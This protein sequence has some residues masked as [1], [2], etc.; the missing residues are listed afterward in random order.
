MKIDRIKAIPVEIPLST[1]YVWSHGIVDAFRNVIVEVST[2]EGITGYG[3]SDIIY[4]VSSETLTGMV[5]VI[6]RYL[7]PDILGQDP[8]DIEKI[9]GL[10]DTKVQGNQ[11]AKAGI[12]YA[13]WDAKGKYLN[14]PV[15]DLLG[16]KCSDS[17]EVDYT[18]GIDKPDAMAKSAIKMMEFGYRTFV[19]KVGRDSEL[20]EARLSEVRKAVGHNIKL[21]LDVNEGYTVD[22]AIKMIRRFERYDPELVEQPVERW[23]IKGMAQVA[24]A[25]ETPISADEGNSSP[26]AALQLIESE[27]VDVLNIKPPYHGGLW[28]SKKIV[29]IAQ[30]A[31]V[32]IIVGGMNHFE[33][34]R[35]AN[36]HFAISSPM[37]SK[38][39][40]EGPGPASQSLTD[41]I[42]TA[43]LEYEDVKN[44]DGFIRLG[45]E[46][47]LGCM[48]D[49]QKLNRYTYRTSVL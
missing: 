34:G 2:D 22:Q 3:E 42:T 37:T 13:L 26:Q 24:R 46:P 21:R 41:N 44:W 40:H 20:D 18:I 5:D 29:S 10:I 33:I 28:N 31:G 12:E 7:A 38:Y 1:N 35:Q 15:Y 4:G 16:G 30:A 47:G 6:E 8:F 19:V 25:V 36:R 43:P 17:I 27:A 32:P 14:L 48:I 49:Q 11:S 9:L 45:K 39:A 23:N